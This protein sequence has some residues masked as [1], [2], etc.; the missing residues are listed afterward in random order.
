MATVVLVQVGSTI[1]FPT[2]YVQETDLFVQ[3]YL[4][5]EILMDPCFCNGA[6]KWD[7]T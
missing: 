2:T 3:K 1:F 7:Q 4:L 5:H 6:A